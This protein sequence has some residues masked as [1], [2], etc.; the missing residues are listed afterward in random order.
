[1]QYRT[2]SNAN[3]PGSAC[4][5]RAGFGVSPK[6]SFLFVTDVREVRD[7]E[8][9]SPAREVRAG[10]ALRALPGA[11]FRASTAVIIL[12]FAAQSLLAQT[13]TPLPSSSPTDPASEPVV[14][15]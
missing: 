1:M 2:I 13:P 11:R 4:V 12:L 15:A 14:L 7:G 8:T 9:P 6:Q 5:S 10:L 3:A